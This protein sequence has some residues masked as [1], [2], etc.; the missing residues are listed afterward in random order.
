MI[1]KG[2]AMATGNIAYRLSA[3]QILGKSGVWKSDRI[4]AACRTTMISIS[5]SV[6][7][8]SLLN[9]K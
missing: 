6:I 1:G 5:C 2:M 8:S 3:Q 4:N 7:L 9:D